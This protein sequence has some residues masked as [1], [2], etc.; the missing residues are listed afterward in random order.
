MYERAKTRVVHLV[1]AQE[2]GCRVSLVPRISLS[3]PKGL[4]ALFCSECLDLP[5]HSQ[6][7]T[8]S[9]LSQPHSMP[10][11]TPS[12]H[13]AKSRG[14]APSHSKPSIC[15]LCP[16]PDSGPTTVAFSLSLCPSA[17]H[18][19]CMLQ[20]KSH[21]KPQNSPMRK[22]GVSA[23]SLQQLRKLGRTTFT[24]HQKD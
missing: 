12:P 3:P 9:V 1:T 18:C 4:K 6:S 2:R 22:A 11:L 17:A 16:P 21:V 23:V 24:T 7:S 5:G 19:S 14:Y 15:S 10:T 20:L 13:T 8:A